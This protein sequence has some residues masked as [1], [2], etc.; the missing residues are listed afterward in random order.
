METNRTLRPLPIN[1]GSKV[2][3][4]LVNSIDGRP[5]ACLG[6]STS[7]EGINSAM[8]VED[9]S[10]KTQARVVKVLADLTR[11]D[12]EEVTESVT[13]QSRFSG[14]S[15]GKGSSGAAGNGGNGQAR[16]RWREKLVARDVPRVNSQG[17]GMQSLTSSDH[18]GNPKPNTGGGSNG[19]NKN[20]SWVNMVQNDPRSLV[21]L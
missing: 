12:R 15:D 6:G 10:T 5:D 13:E 21:E 20:R 8:I 3:E 4:S 17:A 7:A 18:L 1:Y 16:P 14:S 9:V 19:L 2:G 11:F